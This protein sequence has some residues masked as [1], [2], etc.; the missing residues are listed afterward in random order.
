MFPEKTKKLTPITGRDWE[1]ELWLSKW[2]HRPM[3]RFLEDMPT[4]PWVPI[5]PKVPKVNFDLNFTE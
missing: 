3:R 5:T 1:D 4:Y 2:M